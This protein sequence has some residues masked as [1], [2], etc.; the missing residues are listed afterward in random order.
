MAFLLGC[1]T[2]GMMLPHTAS[3]KTPSTGSLAGPSFFGM[4]WPL[5]I[6][7]TIHSSTSYGVTESSVAMHTITVA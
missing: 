5:M 7:W 2:T 3:G 4:P 1:V 6:S